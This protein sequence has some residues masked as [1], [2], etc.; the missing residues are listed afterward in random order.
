LKEDTDRLAELDPLAAKVL[1][2]LRKA[3]L[4]R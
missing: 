3:G 2:A 1:A 4:I